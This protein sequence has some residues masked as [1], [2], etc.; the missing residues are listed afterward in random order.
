MRDRLIVV[1]STSPIGT[2]SSHT[3]T[4]NDPHQWALYSNVHFSNIFV[5]LVVVTFKLSILSELVENLRTT[6]T[7]Q[8]H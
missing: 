7:R 4:C 2:I 1:R 3:Y 5:V 6:T 8:W